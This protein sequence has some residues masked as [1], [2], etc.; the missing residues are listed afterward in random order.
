M[1]SF[2]KNILLFPGAP[3]IFLVLLLP[4]ACHKTNNDQEILCTVGNKTITINDFIMRVETSPEIYMNNSTSP[5]EMLNFLID[6][7]I[8]A[9]EAINAG[10]DKS[11]L[12]DRLVGFIQDMAL[13]RALYQRQVRAAVQIDS[14][15]IDNALKQCVET[16]HIAYIHLPDIKTAD[17]VQQRL[18]TGETFTTIYRELFK[19]EAD[20][21]AFLKEIRWGEQPVPLEQA[22]F[23]LHIGE[24]SPV[25]TLPSGYL[26][27]KLEKIVKQPVI[28]H[29]EYMQK[30]V[31]VRK[32]L[33]ARQE[34]QVSGK[35]VHDF[36]TSQQV[37]FNNNLV[38][39]AIDRITEQL[40]KSQQE[41]PLASSVGLV[42]D[43]L[44]MQ[45]ETALSTW[46]G[47]PVVAFR[48]GSMTLEELLLKWRQTR[49]PVNLSSTAA[50]KKSL[51]GNFSVLVR[52]A[53]LVREARRLGYAKLPEV[54]NDY[55]IWRNHYLCEL[56]TE[57]LDKNGIT[58]NAFIEQTKNKYPITINHKILA[59]I[60]LTNIPVLA[61]RPGQYHSRLTPP[62]P[63]FVQDT[64]ELYQK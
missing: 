47:E 29:T 55:S 4:A 49:L 12:M 8:L 59:N 40:F 37:H 34:E 53:L 60:E 16:R 46:L 24:V 10:L 20:S 27:I 5:R 41:R 19:T 11:P 14:S 36:M 63:G 22:V 45:T 35:Y 25:I 42:S 61:V 54:K 13:S 52:D 39:V 23:S 15:A 51:A 58:V 33:Q 31:M 9:G 50:C 30:K 1:K 56:M 18:A 6:E 43:S 17:T 38:H 2:I 26:V 57:E 62:W 44:F 48:N 32:I 3:A 7:T 64:K 21:L 28:S